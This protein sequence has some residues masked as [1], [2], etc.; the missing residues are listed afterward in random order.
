M[1]P[2]E[3]TISHAQKNQPWTIPYSEGV[4]RA[5]ENGV[6]HILGSHTVLH[7]IKTLGKLAAVFERWDHNPVGTVIFNDKGPLIEEIETIKSMSADLVTAALRFANLYGFDL[8]TVLAERVEEKN[9]VNIL[10][11]PSG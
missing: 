3:L 5:S 11:I 2:N 1:T 4:I 10:S 9:G 8:A 7:A 6:I